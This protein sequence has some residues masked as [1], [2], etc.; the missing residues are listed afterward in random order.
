M[1]NT[2]DNDALVID[3]GPDFRYQMLREHVKKLDAVLITHAHKDHIGG[4]DDVRAFNYFLKKPMDVYAREEDQVHIKNQFFYAFQDEKYPGVPDINL[5]QINHN[6]FF[7]NQTKITPITVFHYKLNIF[8][9]RIGGFTYITDANFIS[10]E[11]K[12]KIA[13]SDVIVLNALRRKK[14]ISHFTFDEAVKILDE[15]KPKQAYLTHISHQL[16]LH[17]EV[18]KELP[19]FIRLAYD[20]LKLEID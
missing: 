2:N 15:L 7:I 1:I 6:P 10:E 14:H 20:G 17:D 19:D 3:T 5:H 16:G 4:L 8:G 18:E 13:G 11:E 9:F 12:E